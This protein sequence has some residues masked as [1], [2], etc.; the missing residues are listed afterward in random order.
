VIARTTWGTTRPTKAISPA[1]ATAAAAASEAA[2]RAVQRTRRVSTPSAAASS[3]PACIRS[4]SRATNGTAPSVARSAAHTVAACQASRP[5]SVPKD[6]ARMLRETIQSSRKS[7][8][9]SWSSP[10]MNVFTAMPTSRSVGIDTRPRAVASTQM[11]APVASAPANAKSGI[12]TRL[13]RFAPAATAR[14]GP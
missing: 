12:D 6:Q 3:R 11:S 9:I 2:A 10:P 13:E 1:T 8:W 7:D 4:S 14:F 5:S